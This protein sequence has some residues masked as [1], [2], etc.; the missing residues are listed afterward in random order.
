MKQERKRALVFLADGS[1]EIETVTA[2]DV[3]RRGGVEVVATSVADKREVVCSRGVRVAADAIL[4]EDEGEALRFAE[5]FDAVVVPGGMGGVN[6]MRD[7]VR[8]LSILR[9]AQSHGAVVAA[10]CAG[11][12]VLG[13]AGVLDGRQFTCYP[14]L[15]DMVPGAGI[16][17]S[18]EE[19]ILCSDN[20][21][22]TST[23]P[24]TALPFA[25][26]VLEFLGVP[27]AK[28]A[29]ETLYGDWDTDIIGENVE[30]Q[31]GC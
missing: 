2:I 28:V 4:P 18:D 27:V 22:V 11:P 13:A 30:R 3:L 24:A 29:K 19:T 8:V 5:G 23:G 26:Q 7:D 20:G 25:L 21:V 15:E 17:A 1:E 14:G 31:V 10:L 16:F 9:A 6:A 12:I